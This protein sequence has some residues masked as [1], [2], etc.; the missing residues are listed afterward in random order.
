MYHVAKT[1]TPGRRF[2][3]SLWFRPIFCLFIWFFC[4]FLFC[5]FVFLFVGLFV[6]FR[7]SLICF[8][9]LVLSFSF[10]SFL[11]F[12]YLFIY[13]FNCFSREQLNNSKQLAQTFTLYIGHIEV[14]FGRQDNLYNFL[15]TLFSHFL[16]FR[17]LLF[18]EYV[19]V[20]FDMHGSRFKGS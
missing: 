19:I 10:P 5:F 11:F 6:C 2:L 1:W 18:E 13:W 15:V 17:L 9:F 14:T 16:C 7:V 12:I 4:L 20:Y 3:W 8:C